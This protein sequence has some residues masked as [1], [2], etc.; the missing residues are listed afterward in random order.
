[1]EFSGRQPC[2]GNV[3]LIVCMSVVLAVLAPAGGYAKPCGDDV[4]GQD[5]PCAC[6]DTVVS[7]LV[8]NADD[9]VTRGRCPGDALVIRAPA[10]A[11]GL[12]IDLGGKVL[13]GSGAG[14]GLWLLAG[15]PGGASIVSSGGPARL[16]GFRDGVVAHGSDTLALVQDIVVAGSRR[17]GV[18]VNAIN[19]AVTAV[20]VIGAG[21]DAFALRGRDY[22]VT[23]TRAVDSGRHGY[24]LRGLRGIVGTAGAG[25]TSHGSGGMGFL[26]DGSWF[27]VTDCV[28]IGAGKD[29]V[30]LSGTHHGIAGCT[31]MDNAGNGMTG[32][33]MTWRLRDNRALGNRFDG[34]VLRGVAVVD[35]GGNIGA[36]NQGRRWTHRPAIQCRINGLRCWN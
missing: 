3:A 8:L 25:N 2:G 17:D 1:M 5:V 14:I 35:D 10:A 21:R 31:V 7:N 30:R 22:R 32:S 6:G 15:G 27:G 36:G 9:P 34:L 33:G 29:G 26:I 23:D 11:Q 12:T 20:E 19:Y 16:D 24:V 18:R 13:R 28:A 4:D